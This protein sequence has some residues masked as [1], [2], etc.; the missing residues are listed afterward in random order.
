MAQALPPG[1][2]TTDRRILRSRRMLMD[3]LA[4]LLKEK[5]FED[6]SI[7]QIADEAT[8]NRATFYPHYL[9]K[10]SLLQAMTGARFRD[11]MGRRGITFTDCDGALR[12]TAL[13]V[14]RRSR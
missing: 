5:D 4:T 3:A 7:Q 8:L 13:G 14:L 2:E 10:N 6:I 12:A 1:T 9:D 11:L